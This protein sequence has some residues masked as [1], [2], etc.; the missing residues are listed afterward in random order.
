MENFP[1][2]STAL[3]SDIL[4]S[5]SKDLDTPGVDL[6][7][8]WGAPQMDVALRGPTALRDTRD[9]TVAV[10]TVDIWSNNIGDARDRYSAEVKANFGNDIGGLVKK[11]GGQLILTGANDYSG[12]TRVEG[13][14]LTVNGSLLRSSATVGGRRHDRRHGPPAEPD[15]RK[16]RG[17]LARRR[18][19]SVRNPDGRGQSELQA[20]L[21][22]V[23]PVQRERRGPIRA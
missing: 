18:R 16:R 22:P 5:S 23:D 8:G 12:P 10:G 1:E 4:V 3:I 17:G 6:R 15:G 9:V 13:G 7:S 2:Y 14:L 21:L 19:Q 20:R 11:G